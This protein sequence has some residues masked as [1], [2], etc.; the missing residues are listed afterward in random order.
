MKKLYRSRERRIIGGVAGGLA[1]Y[2]AVDVTIMRLA[3]ALMALIVPN[4]VLAYILAWI[5]IPEAPAFVTQPKATEPQAQVE[6]TEPG[7]STTTDT[8]D[9]EKSLPAEKDMPPTAGEILDAASQEELN[10]AA[11][12]DGGE[13]CEQKVQAGKAE[14][15]PEASQRP[16]VVTNLP[17]SETNSADSD[18]NRQFF[19]YFLIIMGALVL[20]RKYVPS[21]WL[22]MPLRFLRKW[23]P[24]AIMAL[25]LALILS[26]VRGDN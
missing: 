15:A 11:C 19:G 2:F 4:V 3:I 16:S 25:G 18:R 10:Q 22:N 5:I 8:A 12:P 17:E 24:A 7:P 14:P 20:V 13:P 26:V 23:W 6:T 9:A 21:F 1:D